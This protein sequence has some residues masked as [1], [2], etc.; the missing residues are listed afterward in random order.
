[1]PFHAENASFYQDRLGT[2]IGKAFKKRRVSAGVKGEG[3]ES[4]P[5]Q[6]TRK[7]LTRKFGVDWDEF[8]PDGAMKQTTIYESL[9][10][11]SSQEDA[12]LITN[13]G[14]LAQP[15]PFGISSPVRSAGLDGVSRASGAAGAGGGGG[16][17]GGGAGRGSS[18]VQLSLLVKQKNLRKHNSHQ[19]CENV[20]HAMRCHVMP[21]TLTRAKTGSGQT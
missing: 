6:C 13:G 10:D 14:S 20:F 7:Y 15:S 18:H 1:M 12:E 16:G 11:I 19:W 2:D 17:A 3:D 9:A 8:G 21:E 5:A 4:V